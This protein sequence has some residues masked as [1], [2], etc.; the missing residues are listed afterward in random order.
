MTLRDA[1]DVAVFEFS[2][3]FVSRDLCVP[4]PTRIQELLA[5]HRRKFLLVW[6][7]SAIWSE[8]T[9]AALLT[10]RKLIQDHSG[11]LKLIVHSQQVKDVLQA[12]RMAPILDTYSSEAEALA[13]FSPPI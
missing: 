12:T 7:P 5:A 13:G 8:E 6:L 3:A 2:G 10:S 1:G 11:E 4:L 9:C